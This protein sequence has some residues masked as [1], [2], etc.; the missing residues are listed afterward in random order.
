MQ[1]HHETTGSVFCTRMAIPNTL[2]KG[3]NCILILV[4]I[5]FGKRIMMGIAS[6]KFI[7]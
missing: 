4:T 1:E 3:A 7:L 2:F 5:I 6:Q